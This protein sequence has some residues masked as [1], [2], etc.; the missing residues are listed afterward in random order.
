MFTPNTHIKHRDCI[1]Y[2]DR[3][4]DFKDLLIT[5]LTY[6]Q[7]GGN[8]RWRRGGGVRGC[9]C[10]DTIEGDVQMGR[11]LIQALTHSSQLAC[12]TSAEACAYYSINLPF[13]VRAS[14]DAA[15]AA[16]RRLLSACYSDGVGCSSAVVGIKFVVSH[17]VPENNVTLFLSYSRRDTQTHEVQTG[18]SMITVC[19]PL[20]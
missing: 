16:G 7:K 1:S 15:G 8:I 3:N 10:N 19:R 2:V 18:A 6:L 12:C 9:V 13:V 14:G 17:D 5:V 20:L 4:K 11:G